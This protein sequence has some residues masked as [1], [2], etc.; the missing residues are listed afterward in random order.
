VRRP[1]SA[2]FAG[3]AVAIVC[4][5]CGGSGIPD[6]QLAIATYPGD[7]SDGNQALLEATLAVQDDCVYA[8]GVHEPQLWLPIF[9]AD[10]SRFSGGQL[11]VGG[12][13]YSDGDPIA[14]GG[15]VRSEAGEQES[16][17]LSFARIPEACDA[18]VGT[19][20]VTLT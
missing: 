9:P 2:V 17:D 11:T 12:A 19:W 1:A 16:A 7:G 3:A 6:D 10:V 4:S 20:L 15:G 13:T 18:S 5:G 8:Q 14:L